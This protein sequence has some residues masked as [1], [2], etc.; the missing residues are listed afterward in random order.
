[1]SINDFRNTRG[2]NA[3]DPIY[4]KDVVNLRTL[5]RIIN[6]SSPIPI[7]PISN[8]SQ[9]NLDDGTN[10]HG[11]TKNDVGL[12]NVDNTSDINKPVSN[13]IQTALN[14]KEDLSNKE[15]VIIDNSITKYPTVNLL[16]TGLDLKQDLLNNPITGTGSTG[17]VSFWV[18]TNIQSGDNGLFWN[19]IDKRLGVG[20]STPTDT[21]HVSGTTRITTVN[22]GVGD[23]LTRDSNGVIT[24]RTSSE[25]LT[26]IGAQAE[27]GYINYFEFSGSAVTNIASSNTWYKLNTNSTTSLFSRGD[28]VHTNNRVTNTGSTEVFKIEGIISVSSGNNNEIHAAFFK[29]NSLY[30]CSEQSAILTSGGKSS[31]LPFHCVVELQNNDFIEVWVKNQNATTNITLSNINVIVTQ[32]S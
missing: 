13:A 11:T 30:P 20:I 27:I 26:D 15:N 17:Q 19:N 29:N 8:H 12:G 22:N 5:R 31:A 28:L 9:L 1:M 4:D 16:K 25:V 23:F 3:E 7:P 6:G 18:G 21:F 10:P 32:W 2:V 24:R 14:L